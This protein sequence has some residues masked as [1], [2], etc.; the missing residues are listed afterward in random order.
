ME[1]KYCEIG[2]TFGP[3]TSAIVTDVLSCVLINPSKYFISGPACGK[4]KMLKGKSHF[5]ITSAGILRKESAYRRRLFEVVSYR[6][7][8]IGITYWKATIAILT[9]AML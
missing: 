2:V 6:A 1:N 8:S 9:T 3:K 5:C 4:K 7:D